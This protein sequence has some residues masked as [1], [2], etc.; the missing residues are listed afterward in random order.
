M[1]SRVPRSA[2]EGE[3]LLRVCVQLLG[4]KH[5]ADLRAY[6]V[7]GVSS[8]TDFFLVGSVRNDRQ[9]K[10]AGQN[11]TRQ[12]KHAGVHAF[13]RDG[14]FGGGTWVVLD[15]LDC[16]VHLFSAAAR[17]H[18]NIEGMWRGHELS[19]AGWQ[20]AARPAALP[21]AVQQQPEPGEDAGP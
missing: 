11:L 18:Y 19:I 12:L 17:Q 2:P 21:P 4:D 13:H 15:Y 8:I 6:D 20:Q 16:I 3:S 14:D 9:M 1:R 7:R 10:A 5:V